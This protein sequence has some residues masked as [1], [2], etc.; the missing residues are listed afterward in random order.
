MKKMVM[1]C[2][3]KNWEVRFL[4]GCAFYVQYGNV[5]V[6]VLIVLVVVVVVLIIFILIVVVVVVVFCAVRLPPSPLSLTLFY[7]C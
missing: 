1:S 4:G 2:F 3:L 6:V 7:F 5:V